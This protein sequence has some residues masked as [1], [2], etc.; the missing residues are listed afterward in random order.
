MQA[1]SEPARMLGKPSATSHSSAL[2]SSQE[3][4]HQTSFQPLT[5][6]RNKTGV[7]WKTGIS[8]LINRRLNSI[9]PVL[10]CTR[11]RPLPGAGPAVRDKLGRT[12]G[13]GGSP[14]LPGPRGQGAGLLLRERNP[15]GMCPSAL[16]PHRGLPAPLSKPAGGLLRTSGDR[17]TA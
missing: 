7:R 4:W 14:D 9:S 6:P 13:A 12:A 1:A 10:S 16:A 8:C 3:L 17:D 2:L 15:S 5:L 11:H